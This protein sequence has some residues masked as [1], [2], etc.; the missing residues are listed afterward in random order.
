MEMV[1]ISLGMEMSI[2]VNT[3]MENLMVLAN[4]NGLMEVS[5]LVNLAKVSNMGKV[6]GKRTTCQIAINMKEIIIKIKSMVMAS[7]VG[8]VEMFTKGTIRTI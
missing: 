7:L 6:N 4:T 8:K 2:R 3:N 1:L 5:I